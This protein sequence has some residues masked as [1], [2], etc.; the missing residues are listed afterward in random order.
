MSQD[1]L[2]FF[3]SKFELGDKVAKSCTSGRATNIEVAVVTNL[4]NE[5]LYIGGSKVAI[6][7]PGRLINLTKYK[8]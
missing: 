8:E 4:T 5:K 2:D 3:G 1:L 7:F 6:N